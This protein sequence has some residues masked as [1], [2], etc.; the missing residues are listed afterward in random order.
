MR[1]EELADQ[2]L[3]MYHQ[4][5]NALYFTPE[6]TPSFM[7]K[8][9]LA[10]AGPS[11]FVLEDLDEGERVGR[12]RQPLTRSGHCVKFT[13]YYMRGD[14]RVFKIGF[15]VDS[16]DGSIECE[17]EFP[18]EPALLSYYWYLGNTPI[19]RDNREERVPSILE[20]AVVIAGFMRYQP[21]VEGIGWF[22]AELVMS[23]TECEAIKPELPD[24]VQLQMSGTAI[25]DY[26]RAVLKFV[27]IPYRSSVNPI[28]LCNWR[29]CVP[30][31][32]EGIIFEIGVPDDLDPHNCILKEGELPRRLTKVFRAY[33]FSILDQKFYLE[34]MW[35]VECKN[36]QAV[37]FYSTGR[38]YL[39]CF[40]LPESC[41]IMYCA[42]VDLTEGAL[43]RTI[44]DHI[45]STNLFEF[46]GPTV[47]TLFLHFTFFGCLVDNVTRYQLYE[48]DFTADLYNLNAPFVMGRHM[49]VV[50]QAFIDHSYLIDPENEYQPMAVL[51]IITPDGSF[52]NP[53]NKP[54]P[55]IPEGR[56]T[57][58]ELDALERTAFA[59]VT[60]RLGGPIGTEK[61]IPIEG[62]ARPFNELITVNGRDRRGAGGLKVEYFE[63]YSDFLEHTL[64][65]TLTVDTKEVLSYRIGEFEVTVENISGY[66]N[67][68]SLNTG[69]GV[70]GTLILGFSTRFEL[71]L[72]ASYEGGLWSFQA[73][74]VN[75]RIPL[76][77]ILGR[78]LGWRPGKMD[79]TIDRMF[80][81][82]RTDGAYDLALGI[83]TRLPVFDGEMEIRVEGELSRREISRKPQAMLKGEVE[84]QDFLFG[85]VIRLFDGGQSEMSLSLRFG[86]T[87][88]TAF[89]EDKLVTAEVQNLT[90][91]VLLKLLFKVWRPN[92]RFY[93]PSP[94]NILNRVGF[95]RVV[96]SFH[97]VTK[98]VSVTV[99][100]NLDLGIVR[101]NGVRFAYERPVPEEEA[102]FIVTLD[103]QW[104]AH[105]VMLTNGGGFERRV[106]ENAADP[107][108]PW[109]ALNG[110]SPS[111][112]SEAAGKLFRI[113]YF[114]IGRYINL[115]LEGVKDGKLTA[116]LDQAMKNVKPR[117]DLPSELC[118]TSYSW[119]VGAKFTVLDC[120]DAAL[121]FYDPVLYGLSV[122]VTKNEPL[123][124][125]GLEL[126]VY[127]KKITDRIGLFYVNAALPDCIRRMQFGTLSFT[128]PDIEV[129]IYT[130]GNFKINFGF[131]YNNDFSNSFSLSYGIFS[132]CGGFYFGC[133]NGDTST[134]TPLTDRGVFDPVIELGV[135]FTAG[136]GSSLHAGILSL[137]ARLELTA[138]FT[139]VFA[140]FSYYLPDGQ[141]QTLWYY[142]CTGMVTVAGE[143]AGEVNFFVIS[144]SFRLYVR[145]SLCL[146]LEDGEEGRLLLEASLQ[147]SASIK[148]LFIRIRFSFS[149]RFQSAYVLGGWEPRPW[150]EAAGPVQAE[151]NAYLIGGTGSALDGPVLIFNVSAAPYFSKDG[152]GIT[153]EGAAGGSA[154]EMAAGK[155]VEKIAFLFT[156]EEEDFVKLCCLLTGR[157]IGFVRRRPGEKVTAE[158]L[159]QLMED[160]ESGVLAE[161]FTYQAVAS[162]LTGRLSLRLTAGEDLPEN[163]TRSGVPIPMPPVFEVT[164]ISPWGEETESCGQRGET[165]FAQYA[166]LVTRMGMEKAYSIAEGEEGGSI[167]LRELLDK[168]SVQ[169]GP[170][171]C[172]MASRVML[173]GTRSEGRP[174]Y[175]TI[176]QQFD[177][178]PAAG[179]DPGRAVHTLELKKRKAADWVADDEFRIQIRREEL[180]YPGEPVRIRFLTPP[181]LIRFER[182]MSQVRALYDRQTVYEGDQAQLTLWKAPVDLARLDPVLIQFWEEKRVSGQ[183][184]AAAY[185]TYRPA[186]LLELS[187]SR[188]D[189]EKRV[190]VIR[191]APAGTVKAA[192]K[193][194]GEEIESITVLFSR[195]VR[196]TGENRPKGAFYYEP[197]MN[198]SVYLLRQNLT[199]VTAAPQRDEGSGGDR[200]RAEPGADCAGLSGDGAAFLKLL[201]EMLAIGGDGHYVV[202][203]WKL[204]EL[205]FDDEGGLSLFLLVTLTGT[206]HADRLVLTRDPESGYV[207]VIVNP[208]LGTRAVPTLGPGSAGFEFTAEGEKEG[209]D[210]F[211]L[212]YYRLFGQLSKPVSM[213]EDE[214][215]G[216]GLY[217]G[218]TA[219]LPPIEGGTGSPYERILPDSYKR[220]E[221]CDKNRLDLELF[222]A[223]LTGNFTAQDQCLRITSLPILYY[224]N[225]CAITEIPCTSV[226]YELEKKG[227]G[228]DCLVRLRVIRGDETR[229]ESERLK[230]MG[231]QIAQKDVRLIVRFGL[232]DAW[233]DTGLEE[234]AR[235][236]LLVYLKELYLYLAG[237][238]PGKAQPGGP[239][240]GEP[241]PP[242]CCVLRAHFLSPLREEPKQLQVAKV[243]VRFTIERDPC[244]VDPLTELD[245]AGSVTSEIFMELDPANFCPVF[246]SIF[247]NAKLLEGEG[248]YAAIFPK[249]ALRIMA[250]DRRNAFYSLKP[251]ATGRF[252]HSGVEVQ[253][254]SGEWEREDYFDIDLEQWA[255]DFFAFYEKLLGQDGLGRLLGGAEGAENAAVFDALLKLK[256]EF[257]RQ[258]TARARCVF[259]SAP[260]PE[261][262]ASCIREALLKSLSGGYEAAGA[263]VYQAAGRLGACRL[264]GELAGVNGVTGFKTEE[265]SEVS[266]L[267]A[268]R[269]IGL[270]DEISMKEAV[271]TFTHL[272]DTQAEQWY[273]FV[274]PFAQ[275]DGYVDVKLSHYED[276]SEVQVPVLCRR[277]PKDPALLKQTAKGIGTA[278]EDLRWSYLYQL[279]AALAAQ[280]RLYVELSQTGRGD[281]YR[282]S[283]REGKNLFESLAQFIYNKEEYERRL[284]QEDGSCTGLLASFLETAAQICH[285]WNQALQERDSG[286]ASVL[287][288]K[289]GS[290]CLERLYVKASGLAAAL[291]PPAL[292]ITDPEGNRGEAVL[293]AEG[294]FYAVPGT[295]RVKPGEEADYEFSFKNI[296]L[297]QIQGL[298][299]SLTLKQNEELLGLP[300]NQD[301]VYETQQTGFEKTACP[302][303]QLA[304]GEIRAWDEAQ[305]ASLLQNFVAAAGVETEITALIG[306]RVAGPGL[307]A[308][309]PF[310]KRSRHVLTIESIGDFVGEVSRLL[311]DIGA[312]RQAGRY[313]VK[314]SLRQFPAEQGEEGGIVLLE[315]SG[316]V[317]RVE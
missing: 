290:E 102:R 116:I 31:E 167:S 57:R 221:S 12:Y 15:S 87:L 159:K 30:V 69:L 131:P 55:I 160:L 7:V 68:N 212:L 151:R 235:E 2:I 177:G 237:A 315:L 301:F 75:G 306:R 288:P 13:G 8:V 284:F 270:A 163:E 255:A 22:F 94:W 132:G 46:T 254:L 78:I 49:D 91:G 29:T 154:G 204:D 142:K 43:T 148:I 169:A 248:L 215:A 231:F 147:V 104:L 276:G 287:R 314:L 181:G 205:L 93:L 66:L 145:A 263:A 207:P 274:R 16:R 128:L 262:A 232:G 115:N 24:P 85:A 309:R 267:I 202:I 103:H 245:H 164:W 291:E 311:E 165:F 100:V 81:W 155:G 172:G 244:Y 137:T 162:F 189:R 243:S 241:Q 19:L 220:G 285:A 73:E 111:P 123:P 70:S 253:G 47:Y 21:G 126:T 230:I 260:V 134:Q 257:A 186:V 175:E 224:D 35:C 178:S 119:F 258:I 59:S 265:G 196:Q 23:F 268:P 236:S 303:L 286:E 54:A 219:K 146:T 152:I 1:V 182:R 144:V 294:G 95:S 92:V 201:G 228:F 210:P 113:D 99:A 64:F 5:N 33:I 139:G 226:S 211:H 166:L 37:D 36:Y 107:I 117:E 275:M 130:N 283:R 208:E 108:K 67:Y 193:I 264:A 251:L 143:I 72:G 277:C 105:P 65:V 86:D 80:I 289:F 3:K 150:K 58:I 157:A 213:Q 89:Y 206:A 279:R 83:S 171:L 9:V 122:S 56:D 120:F 32:G 191:T 269:V 200:R 63:A 190:Y 227:Q 302:F 79:L 299:T 129:W 153:W 214:S 272:E 27:E 271:W 195:P 17:V 76:A 101:I 60:E 109:D 161:G 223:D 38:P 280:D 174:L 198:G 118:N 71:E 90:I 313:Y 44:S 88:L 53:E 298:R 11:G 10:L 217:Y 110:D 256:R 222:F 61:K 273:G 106:W 114:G 140:R 192:K 203:D 25:L 45:Q 179:S 209:V 239:Q 225:L 250:K 297:Y 141:E 112:L 18:D 180:L 188:P 282:K 149:F 252:S 266:F 229:E 20:N 312:A 135:G 34:R 28:V 292:I 176:L 158:E 84:L 293:E 194:C 74:L 156:I 259:D 127:Y 42:M 4:E 26:E 197:G 240:P 317:F 185:E 82:Y 98:E 281:F 51:V 304:A 233:S 183:M 249:H 184:R 52:F 242:D 136:V 124:L 305:A 40:D 234:E 247:E 238:Q 138:V 121:L 125:K 41:D 97:T 216:D 39:T 170:D 77:E 300:V 316:E 310:K 14:S 168:L 218:V 62:F 199:E 308:Y 48:V 187:L 246:E 261:S 6:T 295:V 133:L 173:G 50:L 278:P 96:L 307:I 296:G